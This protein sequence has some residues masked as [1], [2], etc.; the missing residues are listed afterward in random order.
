MS[1]H[2]AA[3]QFGVAISTE[4]NWV[5]RL[6]QT[7]SVAPGQ[8][9]GHKPRAI[10]GEHRNRLIARC[11]DRAFTMR[12][13][14]AELATE[15]SLKVDYRLVWAFVH[16]EGLSYKKCVLASEQDRSD[17]AHRRAQWR[18]YQ[19]RIDPA[20]LVFIDETW[21]KIKMAPLRGWGRRGDRLLGKVPYG[22]WN[23]MTFIAALRQD[24]IDA[25][26]LLD[27]P[28]SGESFRVYVE[29]VLVPTLGRGDGVIMDNFGSH[30]GQQSGKPFAAPV[31]S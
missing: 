18:R 30:K 7:A 22:H 9:G 23:T 5:K 4:I 19:A 29:Q 16:A 27:G 12:G 20:R 17:I 21:T 28:V 14:A 8:M 2:Q 25:P 31:P 13:L 10:S 1:R 15:R 26:W 11:G 3:A 6:R 24:R